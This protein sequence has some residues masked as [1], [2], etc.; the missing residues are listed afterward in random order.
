[1]KQIP[2]VSS[3]RICSQLAEREYATQKS[4]WE[5]N[6]THLP[7]AC[8]L[9]ESVKDL[10]PDSSRSTVLQR[11]P[12]CGMYYLYQSDY[13]YLA[14]GSEDTQQL[15]RLSEEQAQSYLGL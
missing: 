12:E 3:C 14:G 5:E 6:N 13:E 11:C 7:A 8:G 1:M 9:L 10:K 15:T 2:E 4:G